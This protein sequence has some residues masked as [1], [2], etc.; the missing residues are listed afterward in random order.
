MLM[1]TSV[2]GVESGELSTM[3]LEELEYRIMDPLLPLSLQ[4]L[5]P[6]EEDEEEEGGRPYCA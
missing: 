1:G 5:S 3:E 4:A 2:M 6:L